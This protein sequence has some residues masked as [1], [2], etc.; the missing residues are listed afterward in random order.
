MP[1]WAVSWLFIISE[2]HWALARGSLADAL[3]HCRRSSPG[4]LLGLQKGR[5]LWTGVCPPPPYSSLSAWYSRLMFLFFW[6]LKR[7]LFT[8]RPWQLRHPHIHAVPVRSSA[9]LFQIATPR[10]EN[11]CLSQEDVIWNALQ[12]KRKVWRRKKKYIILFL[13]CFF[14]ISAKLP[15]VLTV[16]SQQRSSGSHVNGFRKMIA[17]Q[18]PG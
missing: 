13:F 6:G 7:C 14:S 17:L 10:G 18:I 3:S 9:V 15:Q 5:V 11:E 12:K 16:I 4:V 1:S 8:L 2:C